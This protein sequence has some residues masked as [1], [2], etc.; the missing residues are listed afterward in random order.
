MKLA[1]MLAAIKA[2]KHGES[3]TFPVDSLEC[4][5]EVGRAL[6]HASYEEGL[7]ISYLSCPDRDC[8]QP[9]IRV[10]HYKDQE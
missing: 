9:Y 2:T 4:G 7:T 5:T 10:W 8:K 3:V 6:L 1:R